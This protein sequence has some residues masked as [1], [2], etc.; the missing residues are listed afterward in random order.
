MS[1]RRRWK[2]ESNTSCTDAERQLEDA[3]NPRLERGKI[4]AYR[5]P[6]AFGIVYSWKGIHRA[7][8]QEMPFDADEVVQ[9]VN[10]WA[11]RMENSGLP[12]GWSYEP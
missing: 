11:N 5:T 12:R 2:F 1:E 6:T 3:V 4:S 8:E 9:M 10:E 7:V